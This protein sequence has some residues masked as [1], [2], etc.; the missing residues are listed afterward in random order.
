MKPNPHWLHVLW[1]VWFALDLGTGVVREWICPRFVLG[2]I[3]LTCLGDMDSLQ[4]LGADLYH[5]FAGPTPSAAGRP[6]HG[7]YGPG[8]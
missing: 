2:P 5:G 3:P 7:P 4:R 6:G 1:G 8:R